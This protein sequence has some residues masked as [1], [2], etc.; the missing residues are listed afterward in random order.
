M[1]RLFT[2]GAAMALGLFVSHQA[3]A[4]QAATDHSESK[5]AQRHEAYK[6]PSAT[7]PGRLDEK[8]KGANIRA[9]QLIGMNIQ[10]SQGKSLGEVN[11]LV[12]DGNTGKVKYAAVTYGGFLGFGDK[13]FAVPY[14]AFKCG[15]DPDD[16]DE[17]VLMLNVNQQQLEGAEGFDQDNW[18]DFA[19]RNFT[20]QVDKRYG[21]DRRRMD[22]RRS[23]VNVDV[24]RNGVNN[25]DNRDKR[26][27]REE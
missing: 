8:M 11:D 25:R 12:I 9:S 3:L 24:N 10:N 13:L 5:T 2:L 18:P 20:S 14:E 22:H 17:H 6:T 4:E 21:V 26:D 16:P 27:K 23:G 1:T 7:Q 19:D 15:T